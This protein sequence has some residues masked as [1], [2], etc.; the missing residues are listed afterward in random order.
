MYRDD[1]KAR[2]ERANALI[3][4]IARLEREK[5]AAAAGER[6]LEE[7]RKELETLRLPST[8]T[9][10]SVAEPAPRPPSLATHVLVFCATAGAAF[11]GYSLLF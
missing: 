8:S 1:D 3:D 2:D 9:S 10:A 6:R 5:V 11:A 7:A 4:E